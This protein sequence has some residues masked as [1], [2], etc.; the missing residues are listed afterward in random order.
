M[1]VAS[2]EPAVARI[3]VAVAGIEMAAAGIEVVVADIEAAVAGIEMVVAGIEAAFSG[4]V[5]STHPKI[6][7]LPPRIRRVRLSSPLAVLVST[8]ALLTCSQAEDFRP[9][10]AVALK[11]GEKRIVIPPGVYRLDPQAGGEL[12][13][14][15]N[16]KD[17]EI[18]AD[19]VTL[20]GTKL[21]RAISLFRCSGV[22]L[23]GLTI[24]YDPLPFTQGT[25]IADDPG[26]IDVKLHA[27]YP[28]KP[29]ARID[30]IDPKTRFRK[31]GMPFLWGT[32]AEM[33]SED[34]VRVKLEGIA[35]TAKIGDLVSL[36]TGQEV[37]APHAVSVEQC[38][39][40]HFRNVTV[41][42]APGMGILEADGEGG[43]SFIGCRILPG[44]K[45]VGAS[46]ERL[47]S[48]SWD[49]FQ[50]K[51]IRKGPWVEDCEINEAGDDSWS[52][53]SSDFLVLSSEGTELVL[54]SRDEFTD[55]VQ[56]GDRLRARIT[57]PEWRIGS[58]KV[59]PRGEAGLSSEVLEQLARAEAWSKWKV[60]PK[61]LVL[62]LDKE[63]GLKSG[64]SVYSPDRMGNGFIFRNN[65]LHSP[66]RVL[67]K[68]GG[69]AEGNLL[70]TPHALV[71]CAE[72]PG[73]SAIGIENLVIRK[74]TIRQA[75]R[76]CA[77]PWSSQA[78]ALSLSASLDQSKT[79]TDSVFRN[80][81][82]EDNVFESCA[83]P[84]L[85]I[86]SAEGV[87]VRGN[88]FVS[89]QQDAPPDTGASYGIAKNSVVWMEN[90]R[91]VTYERN[92]ME[93]TGTF[94]G[95]AIQLSKGMTDAKGL[96]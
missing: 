46:E 65:R 72:L 91:D 63:S 66:G 10:V 35:R 80:I 50:S 15:S 37:G 3:E 42:S 94:A 58:R 78:G 16:L 88:R 6:R 62:S 56:T 70:D 73:D 9:A 20:V 52:V 18:V 8:I 14:L 82:I 86:T 1:A 45:P 79:R 87:I 61:C 30:V 68:A 11:Q 51:T 90:S 47:L 40:I 5:S 38:S 60:G 77:A 93:K 74:N 85:V 84:N 39:A 49:A 12:W 55:G 22:T 7:P 69:L 2:I 31:K 96:E 17:V 59:V 33:I 95:K 89:A 64:D 48:T 19:G 81:L 32:K 34:V 4:P 57:G 28:R 21:M 41:H 71:V 27:G 43:S 36:S 26:F 76:F 67:L 92:T 44:P 13:N 29:Y 75:G 24:D 53:Q 23:R 54:A 83:G 25:V